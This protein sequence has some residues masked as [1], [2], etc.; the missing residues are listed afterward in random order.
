MFAR[1]MVV[2]G[3]LAAIVHGGQALA[4]SDD[5]PNKPVRIVVPFA[6]GGGVDTLA[7]LL[8]DRL[9]E[10]VARGPVRLL[11]HLHE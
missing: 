8:A 11:V 6:A 1:I 7:R 2:I 10:P 3:A 5:F 4:K 9:K